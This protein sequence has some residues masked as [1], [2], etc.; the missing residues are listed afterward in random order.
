V[1]TSL[2]ILP[3]DLLNN[4]TDAGGTLGAITINSQPRHG[5]WSANGNQQP[6]WTYN[7][8]PTFHGTDYFNYTRE[9][10][11]TPRIGPLG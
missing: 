11:W 5:V 10:K 9:V 1:E 7:P 8:A 4:D 6:G 3:V 2:L